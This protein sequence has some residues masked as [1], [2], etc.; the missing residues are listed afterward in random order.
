[1]LAKWL[2]AK[3]L[4]DVQEQEKV[5]FRNKIQARVHRI[6][7]KLRLKALLRRPDA[8]GIVFLSGCLYGK[9]GKKPSVKLSPFISLALSLLQAKATNDP[10]N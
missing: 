7:L 2:V 10:S 6:R 8:L 9:V 5:I 1:M 4:H 3:P